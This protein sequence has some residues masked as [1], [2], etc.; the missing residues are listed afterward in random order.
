MLY[1]LGFY[2][3]WVDATMGLARASVGSFRVSAS[4]QRDLPKHAC[5]AVGL[6]CQIERK[7]SLASEPHKVSPEI[8]IAGQ[9]GH[10]PGHVIRVEGVKVVAGIGSHLGQAAHT[11]AGYRDA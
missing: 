10:A 11:A 2:S 5:K 6:T 4:G 7:G 1:R 9:T 8:L 3:I